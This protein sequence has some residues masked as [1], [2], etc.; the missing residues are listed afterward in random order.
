M[1]E[2][3]VLICLLPV[4]D[5]KLQYDYAFIRINY[6]S[7]QLLSVNIRYLHVKVQH[8]NVHTTSCFMVFM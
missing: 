4:S 6:V 7:M 1:Y 2:E 5:F 8:D 3:I